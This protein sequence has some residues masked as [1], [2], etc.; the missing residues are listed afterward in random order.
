VRSYNP[1]IEKLVV[2]RVIHVI[3]NSDFTRV[4]A[5]SHGYDAMSTVKP[6][7]GWRER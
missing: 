4:A 7:R 5:L 6:P 1:E 3:V 2:T